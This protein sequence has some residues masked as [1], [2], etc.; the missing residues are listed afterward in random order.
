MTILDIIQRFVFYV[1][2]RSCSET[3]FCLH[4]QLETPQLLSI[5][6]AIPSSETAW[7]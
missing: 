4:L 7:G 3:G 5:D 6:K 1:Y 2:N